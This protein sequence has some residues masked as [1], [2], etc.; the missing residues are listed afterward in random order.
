MSK[1][2]KD[3]FRNLLL[4][5]K[6]KFMNIIAKMD[7]NDIGET[8]RFSST[9]LSSY[10]NHPAELG[11][12]VFNLGM[13]LN[14]KANETNQIKEIERALKKIDKG[15]YGNCEMCK[16]EI[17]DERLDV[18]PYARLCIDCENEQNNEK[19]NV[20]KARPIEE[21]V[22]GSPF[23][24][25]YLNKQEDDE[26]E[27]LDILNDLMKYGSS[28]SPQDMGG[29]K[30]YEEYYTNKVDNQGNVDHMDNLSN[31]DYKKQIPD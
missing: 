9:E 16:K 21:K 23:G 11:T 24:K 25:K 6:E 27:G 10:D 18:R 22:I 12:E 1:N 14:L 5:E 7:E 26:H 8:S 2:S 29:F 31:S 3:Y 17:S 30:D 13:N 4:K 15:N 28:S 20:K 19:S